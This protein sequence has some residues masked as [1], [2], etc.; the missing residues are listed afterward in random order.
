MDVTFFASPVELRKWLEA[1]HG[2][3]SELWIGLQ[4]RH[5]P[6]QGITYAEAV[7]QALCF[8]WIDGTARRIDDTSFTVR[9]TPRRP[10]SNWSDVNI[11]KAQGLVARG[12][13]APPG[14]RAFEARDRTQTKSS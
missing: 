5:S 1:N 14:L 8:G 13:M 2:R 4:K 9:F 12:L 10:N 7:D 6:N 3:V 11:R